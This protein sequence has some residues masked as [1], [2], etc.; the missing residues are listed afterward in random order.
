MWLRV[1]SYAGESGGLTFFCMHSITGRILW[2]RTFPKCPPY[3]YILFCYLQGCVSIFRKRRPTVSLI[4][5]VY[6]SYIFPGCLLL[7]LFY[8]SFVT[9][10]HYVH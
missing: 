3:F 4:W 2:D 5:S 10:L 7:L 6:F 1:S 9:I 8:I